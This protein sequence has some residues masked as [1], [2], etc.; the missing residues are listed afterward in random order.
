MTLSTS[1]LHILCTSLRPTNYSI[2][3]MLN[4]LDILLMFG[5][6]TMKDE[7]LNCYI[8]YN[9]VFEV[10]TVVLLKIQFVITNSVMES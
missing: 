10:L 2:L 1:G 3:C 4:F 7:N 8:F 5:I 6:R 9:A